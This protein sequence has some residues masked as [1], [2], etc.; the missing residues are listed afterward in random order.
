MKTISCE[1]GATAISDEPTPEKCFS[2]KNILIPVD[3]S[4]GSMEAL[5]YGRAL[6]VASCAVVHAIYAMEPTAIV[7]DLNGAPIMPPLDC[8]IATQRGVDL[9]ELLSKDAPKG[10]VYTT[11]S[12]I[13]YPPDVIKDMIKETLADLVVI[14]THGRT[15][16]NRL[17][18]GSVTERVIHEGH[19]PVLV[20]KAEQDRYCESPFRLKK[21]LLPM[22]LTKHSKQVI[23]YAMDWACKFGAEVTLAHFIPSFDASGVTASETSASSHVMKVARKTVEHWLEDTS[24]KCECRG[25]NTKCV[26]LDGSML[27]ELPDYVRKEGFD[28]VVC[29]TH[30][31]GGLRHLLYGSTAEDL[32]RQSPCPVLIVK[33]TEE[34][35]EVR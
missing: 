32:M 2:L 9:D 6:G 18:F 25:V 13:G 12:R 34:E 33:T 35:K 26:A 14:S 31:F 20:L 4:D 5:K 1:A 10:L 24:K 27:A 11:E 22:D 7:A 21:I 19:C 3:F 23:Q 16:L 17:F 15:G 28:L 29:T 30:G 8:E